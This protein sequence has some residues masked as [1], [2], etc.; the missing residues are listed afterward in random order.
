MQQVLDDYN[1]HTINNIWFEVQEAKP[2][3]SE[4]FEYN[5]E[6]VAVEVAPRKDSSDNEISLFRESK[7]L[8][9]NLD[10]LRTKECSPEK[11][12]NLDISADKTKC[13]SDQDSFNQKENATA[14]KP[15]RKSL[16]ERLA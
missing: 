13:Q 6:D 8:Q 7:N 2:K 16:K 12:S 5:E 4:N 11:N 15:V 10:G 9:Q 1:Y 14:Q 3:F